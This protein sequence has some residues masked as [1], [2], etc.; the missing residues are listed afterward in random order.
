MFKILNIELLKMATKAAQQEIEWAITSHEVWKPAANDTSLHKRIS[1]SYAANAF[2]IIRRSLRDEMILALMRMWD[3]EKESKSIS[4]PKIALTLSD[5]QTVDALTA[6][7]VARFK[8]SPNVAAG[9]YYPGIE[10]VIRSELQEKATQIIGLIK[11]YSTGGTHKNVFIALRMLRDQHLA[12]H[13]IERRETKVDEMAEEIKSFYQDHLHIVK[14]L[15]SLVLSV[16]YDLQSTADVYR[17]YAGYF[18]AS[19]RSERVEGHPNYRPK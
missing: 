2:L 5:P 11:K 15:L 6:E 14:N 18:W 4:L 17:E 19:V 12:H 8:V 13:Q 3:G 16:S 7:R 1:Y 9:L 10:D